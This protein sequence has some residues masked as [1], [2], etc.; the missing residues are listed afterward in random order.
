MLPA[1]RKNY[2]VG[3]RSESGFTLIEALIAGVILAIGVLGVVSLL[4]MSKVSQHESIQRVRAVSLADDILERIRRNPNGMAVYDTGLASPLGGESLGVNAPDPDCNASACTTQ[5]LATLDLWAW[6]R[7][8]DGASTT[9][10]DDEGEVS[11]TS[12]MR[13]VRACIDFTAD[14]LKANTGMVDIVLQWQGL[15]KSKDAVAAGGVVCGDD[16]DAGSIR[17]Q[18]IVSSYVIDEKEL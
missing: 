4:S 15:N 7:L 14:S 2:A 5:E 9:V 12:R 3:A 1:T 18:L 6:E 8:L 16:S 10:T 11:S 13:N 17:R